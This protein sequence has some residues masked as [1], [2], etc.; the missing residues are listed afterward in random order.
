LI[1]AIIKHEEQFYLDERKRE[2]EA[3][4]GTK[5]ARTEVALND[6]FRLLKLEL[7]NMEAAIAGCEQI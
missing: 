7:R 4:I 1:T 3:F 2:E 6:Q 5:V